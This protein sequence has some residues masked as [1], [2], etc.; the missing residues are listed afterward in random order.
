[1]KPLPIQG[2]EPPRG[3]PGDAEPLTPSRDGDLRDRI[4]G[5]TMIDRRALAEDVRRLS[6]L[7]SW[8]GLWA[9]AFQWAVIGCS[10]W[11]AIVIHNWAGYL[12]AVLV[13]ATRQHALGILMHDAA[14]Y[15][16]LA[17]RRLNDLVSDVFLALP[18]GFSTSLY[19]RQHFQHHRFT[20]CENDSDLLLSRSWEGF[21]WPKAMA[22]L[23][24]VLRR[25]LL[26]LN[27]LRNLKILGLFSPWPLLRRLVGVRG[28]HDLPP[29]PIV[30]TRLEWSLFVLHPLALVVSV[31]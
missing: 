15:R 9:V 18:L 23:Q 22:E 5:G 11:V 6:E 16:L 13:I 17:N 19:R 28:Y 24:G 1:V 20:N 12:L 21:N 7:S 31:R 2:S 3:L 25:D 26:G 30:F 29:P 27:P 14:H 8:R 4:L 10:I